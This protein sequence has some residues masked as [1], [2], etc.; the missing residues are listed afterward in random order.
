[1]CRFH[2]VPLPRAGTLLMAVAIALQTGCLTQKTLEKWEGMPLELSQVRVEVVS[3]GNDRVVLGWETTYLGKRSGELEFNPHMP[4]C[5]EVQVFIKFGNDGRR[6]ALVG[7]AGDTNSGNDGRQGALVVSAGDIHPRVPPGPCDVD[8]LVQCL[9]GE[10]QLKANTP[11]RPPAYAHIKTPRNHLWLTLVPL[12]AT[13]DVLA[14]T[15]G[16]LLARLSN[17]YGSQ[18]PLR[19]PQPPPP[20]TYPPWFLRY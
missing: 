13:A 8:I 9:L 2:T 18:N 16:V 4:D 14:A 10:L 3:A 15:G 1:M 5:E 7:A 11:G 12:A 20:P 19:H 6:G 17:W